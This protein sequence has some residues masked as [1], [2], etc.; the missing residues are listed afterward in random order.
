[1]ATRF[2]PRL[3]YANVAA[4]L[5]LVLGTTGFAIAGIT[6]S[7]GTL[8]ACMKKKGGDLRVLRKGKCKRTEKKISLSRGVQQGPQGSQGPAGSDA[9]FSG[10]AAG[11]ALSGTYPNPAIAS[12]AVTPSKLGTI[13][14]ARAY[15]TGTQTI[16]DDASAHI[17]NL[18]SE[19]FDTANM[20]DNV[21]NNSRLTAPIGGT[22]QIDACVDWN[23]NATG[24][25]SLWIGRGGLPTDAGTQVAAA[26]AIYP[27]Q[28]CAGDL[29]Q[30][31]A[32][33]YIEM[34]VRQTSGGDLGV[35]ISGLPTF[36]AMTWVGPVA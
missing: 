8:K 10:A 26:S 35:G 17:V 36:L 22:Y 34:S 24:V 25:R 30:L 15:T 5:A 2:R 13:P 6:G 7:S 28:Q 12:G 29:L 1:M 33:E 16:A 19:L 4:T 27:A 23:A 21:T 31:A 32:G 3:T 14:Q 20:H 18:G 9:Q 11:G